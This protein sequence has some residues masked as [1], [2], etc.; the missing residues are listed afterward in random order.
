[1]SD[2]DI[3]V[4]EN[5]AIQNMDH[6][7]CNAIKLA[8]NANRAE[9]LVQL[10]FASAYSVFELF[11]QKSDFNKWLDKIFQLA[12]EHLSKKWSDDFDTSII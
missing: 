7:Y 6:L 2:N 10:T 12:Y 8:R 1:M 3:Q 5:L 11:D 9:D 4:F